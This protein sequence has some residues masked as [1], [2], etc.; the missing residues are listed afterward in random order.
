MVKWLRHAFAVEPAGSL[1]PT[2]AEAALV[3]RLAQA[4]VRRGMAMPA[5]MALDCS[6]N[7][8]FLAS[9]ALVFFAPILKVIFNHA[10]YDTVV[11]LL[12]R[13]GSI[14]YICRRIDMLADGDAGVASESGPRQITGRMK[15]DSQ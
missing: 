1:E 5:T 6:H 14:E 15:D 7:L 13:R 4:V 10:E 8:N 2:P 11:R 12:E 9:Q 3:D